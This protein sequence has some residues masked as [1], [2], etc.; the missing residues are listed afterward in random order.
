MSSRVVFTDAARWQVR[1]AVTSLCRKD[2]ASGEG[3]LGDVEALVRDPD[4]LCER[5]TRLPEF[6]D[7]PYREVVSSGYRVF[8]RA[9]GEVLWIAGVW[10]AD[11]E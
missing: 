7:L 9:E 3:F 5:A 11:G 6:P 2:R 10:R 1:A 8:L 4:L